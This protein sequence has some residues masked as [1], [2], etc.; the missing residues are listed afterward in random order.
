MFFSEVVPNVKVVQCQRSG[1]MIH[2]NVLSLFESW[3]DYHLSL[4][5]IFIISLIHPG[6]IEFLRYKESLNVLVTRPI[7]VGHVWDIYKEV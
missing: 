6:N 7:F 5:M 1:K 3:P 2:F 4:L